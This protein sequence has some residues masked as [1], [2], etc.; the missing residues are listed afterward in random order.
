LLEIMR[1]ELAV[2]MTLGNAE[3]SFRTQYELIGVVVLGGLG[4]S[5]RH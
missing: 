5:R 4:H 1:K 2:T 3:S